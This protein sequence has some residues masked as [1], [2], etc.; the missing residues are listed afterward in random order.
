MSDRSAKLLFLAALVAGGALFY[1][2]PDLD[3][4]LLGIRNHRY[5]LFHSAILPLAAWLWL[6]R[7]RRP[8]LAALAVA[9][10]ASFALGV[11]VHLAADTFQSKSVV[12]PIVGTLVRGT[13]LDDRLWEGGN[14]AICGGLTYVAYRGWR[15]K[16]RIGRTTMEETS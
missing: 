11:G 13:S 9:A 2:F 4:R 1:G 15:R 6:R 3:I 14:A 10:A 5:F 8:F 7:A 16:R 12:F